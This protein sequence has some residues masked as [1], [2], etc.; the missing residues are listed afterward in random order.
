MR[1]III[2]LL[3]FVPAAI[4]SG[5]AITETT[6]SGYNGDNIYAVGY[7]GYRPY[8]G[9]VDSGGWGNVGYWRGYR[10]ISYQNWHGGWF[11]PRY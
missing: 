9:D 1:K 5:C 4:L 7:Y 11:G 3:V 10:A 2:A 6:S 8:I